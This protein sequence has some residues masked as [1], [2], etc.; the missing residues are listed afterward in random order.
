[1]WDISLFQSGLFGPQRSLNQVRISEQRQ[2]FRGRAKQWGRYIPSHL[3]LLAS[4]I[5]YLSLILFFFKCLLSIAKCV[6]NCFKVYCLKHPV[7]MI[8]LQFLYAVR[9]EIFLLWFNKRFFWIHFHLFLWWW[10]IVSN[11]SLFTFIHQL[12]QNCFLCLYTIA[13]FTSW[14]YLYNSFLKL[15]EAN[16]IFYQ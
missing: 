16:F 1:M 9:K 4:F 15:L 6:S 2:T 13:P 10:E 14:K 5:I 7:A 12:S 8:F 11:H 3:L